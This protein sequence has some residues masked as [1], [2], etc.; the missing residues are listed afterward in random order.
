MWIQMLYIYIGFASCYRVVD[1]YMQNIGSN[2]V[3][4]GCEEFDD[5]HI[6]NGFI[7]EHSS[8]VCDK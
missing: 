6:I 1:G 4:E 7:L 5:Y 3:W 8:Q 2:Q